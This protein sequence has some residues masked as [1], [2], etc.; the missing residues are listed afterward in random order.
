MAFASKFSTTA[1]DKTHGKEDASL[2]DLLNPTVP[3]DGPGNLVRSGAYFGLGW[4]GR[5]Y[6]DTKTFGL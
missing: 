5:G 4:I 6:R 1:T 3:L 2:M